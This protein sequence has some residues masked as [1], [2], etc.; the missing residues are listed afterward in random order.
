MPVETSIVV[1]T[2]NEA[3][4][5]ED[6]MKGIHQ[7]D[8]RDWEIILVDSGSTDA[9]VEIAKKYGARIYH[10][11]KDEFTFGRSLNLGCSKARGKYLVFASGHVAPI[12]N[13]W[14]RNIVKPFQD[15]NVAMV[16]GRQ[17]A[18]DE[19]RL[20]EMRDLENRYG[21][22]SNILL[23]EAQA[24]NG[25][26]AVRQE[27]WDK[28]PFDEALPG[29]EDVDWARKIEQLGYRVYYAAEAGVY[30][31]HEE[32]LGQVYN[33]YEREAVAAKRMF[34]NFR[35]NWP[36]VVKGLPYSMIQDLFFGLGHRKFRKIPGIPGTRMAQFLGIFRGVRRQTAMAR[37]VISRLSAP[38]EYSKIVVA[39][40][41]KHGTMRAAI[42]DLEAGHVL[43]QVA[44]AGVSQEDLRTMSANQDNEEFFPMVPGREYSGVVIGNLNGAGNSRKWWKVAG[45]L[46]SGCGDCPACDAGDQNWCS[47]GKRSDSDGTYTGVL[48]LPSHEVHRLPSS[49]SLKQ[50]A[51]VGPAA[52]CLEGLN[53][54]GVEKGQSACVVGAGPMGNLC[55]QIL[56]KK[57]VHVTVV[58][59]QVRWLG[60]L[61][62][63]DVDT[64]AKLGE[65]GNF[66]HL[67]ETSGD[68]GQLEELIEGAGPDAKLLLLGSPY[69]RPTHQIISGAKH[70][71]YIVSDRPEQPGSAWI[72]AIK[73]IQ[74]G[75]ICL[76][77]HT[78][79]VEPLE[80]YKK[81][82]ES[83]ETAESIRVLLSFNP[84]LEAL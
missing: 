79:M 1:R 84:N 78:T 41:G 60:H 54:L 56:Q 39:S 5:L 13:N 74:S 9:S 35:F 57:G 31:V 21:L 83:V 46:T 61:F 37:E 12:T 38:T 24:N 73:L 64:L 17:R 3:K 70:G 43:V 36:D 22:T 11:P 29:L 48:S 58:D 18:T 53:Q 34:P 47:V 77:E 19:N 49:M 26:S 44:F 72:Q 82:W 67:I 62:K 23:D 50:G 7:Q 76:D 45:L 81:A 27:L 10:I 28:I 8:Y 75:A 68:D 80:S 40:P 6:L 15:D 69:G 14:L 66:D 33:R 30:H 63:Y 16:Y 32:T 71:Q 52:R 4:H 59:S 51:S 25:N 65:L 55:A 42:G 20:S 2:L